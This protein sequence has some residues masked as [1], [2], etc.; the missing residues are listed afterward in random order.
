MPNTKWVNNYTTGDPWEDPYPEYN[1]CTRCGVSVGQTCAGSTGLCHDCYWLRPYVN[2]RSRTMYRPD[3]ET[4]YHYIPARCS[5]MVAD[6]AALRDA[7]LP[8]RIVDILEDPVAHWYI[9]DWLRHRTYP[10]TTITRGTTLLDHWS[11][12]NTA[13]IRR[14]SAEVARQK[15]AAPALSGNTQGKVTTV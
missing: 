9:T 6:V 13:R 1:E 5:G 8:V 7:G 10:V 12:T 15:A 11:G 3:F 14:W 4:A 2:D